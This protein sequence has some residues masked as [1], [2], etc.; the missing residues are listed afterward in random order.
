MPFQV[1]ANKGSGGHGSMDSK[2]ILR[3]QPII[4]FLASPAIKVGDFPFGRHT[5]RGNRENE[6][7]L[8]MELAPFDDDCPHH[9]AAITRYIQ[10]KVSRMDSILQTILNYLHCNAFFKNF[11]YRTGIFSSSEVITKASTSI[12][13]PKSAKRSGTSITSCCKCRVKAA[14]NL[15]SI[16]PYWFPTNITP[17]NELF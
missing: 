15:C 17:L 11:S 12:I 5:H 10:T 6:H 1:N 13:W 16:T 4:G 8:W 9:L 2:P 14:N 7:S 3:N